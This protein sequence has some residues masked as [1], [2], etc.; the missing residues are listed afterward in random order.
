M[1]STTHP[2]EK[3]T[4]MQAPTALAT[5]H[6]TTNQCAPFVAADG[7]C[8]ICGRHPVCEACPPKAHPLA[9]TDLE[10]T[11]RDCCACW[12]RAILSCPGCGAEA[13]QCEARIEH[14][15]PARSRSPHQPID[16]EV[17]DSTP[18]LRCG[19]EI[20]ESELADA[21]LKYAVAEFEEAIDNV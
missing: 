19:A 18:C 20:D 8:V 7:E 14:N 16:A 12:V 13:I 2:T 6:A 4:A 1:D 5:D 17:T 21:V 9:V 3:E 10:E 15:H 11:D